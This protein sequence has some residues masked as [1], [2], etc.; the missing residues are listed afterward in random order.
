L[1]KAEGIRFRRKGKRDQKKKR[2]LSF[3]KEEVYPPIVIIEGAGLYCGE[4]DWEQR[5]LESQTTNGIVASRKTFL[6]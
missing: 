4:V 3:Q 1:E 2:R 5:Y 6:R